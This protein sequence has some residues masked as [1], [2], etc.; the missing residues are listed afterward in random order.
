MRRYFLSFSVLCRGLFGLSV[1]GHATSCLVGGPRLIAPCRKPVDREAL[2][3]GL[4][5]S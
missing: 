2:I 4:S 5:V 3:A 1:M